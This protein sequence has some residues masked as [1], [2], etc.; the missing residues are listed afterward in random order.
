MNDTIKIYNL[1]VESI[2]RNGDTVTR[3]YKIKARS[4][5]EA[6]YR[7]TVFSAIPCTMDNV[8]DWKTVIV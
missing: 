6:E 2:G 5:K 4:I 7:S 3:T 8:V 1:V